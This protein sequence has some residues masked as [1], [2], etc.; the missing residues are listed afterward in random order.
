M[1]SLKRPGK[2]VSALCHP[3][4]K[5]NPQD[6]RS[7]RRKNGTSRN[8]RENFPQLLHYHP[9]IPVPASG[10]QAA[11]N[12]LAHFY[13]GRRQPENVILNAYLYYEEITTTT[14]PFPSVSS[15]S[16]RPDWAWR[17]R[18]QLLPGRG[19]VDLSDLKRNTRD[20]IH[21]R[22]YGRQ[23]HVHRDGFAGF[24]LK[25]AYFL[26]T[27]PPRANGQATGSG[28]A[29]KTAEYLYISE[30]R[31]FFSSEDGEALDITSMAKHTVWMRT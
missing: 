1:S 23:L 2:D 4:L 27:H 26:C 21:R 7:C 5:I 8:S 24:R 12:G 11:R 28:S 9:A 15:A 30:N 29:L 6:D 25:E 16:W 14:P 22:Q 3:D 31:M 19:V 10:V 13:S 20:G 17:K 18:R